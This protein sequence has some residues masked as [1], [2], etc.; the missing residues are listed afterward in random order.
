[1]SA[2]YDSYLHDHKENVRLAMEWMLDN[3][4]LTDDP[5]VR[6]DLVEMAEHHDDSKLLPDEYEAYDQYFYDDTPADPSIVND[7]NKA[8]MLHIHR[9]PHHWQYWLLFHD[10]DAVIEP[11]EMPFTYMVEM[12]ADWWSFS[13]KKGNLFEIFDWYEGRR[14]DQI[15]LHSKTRERVESLLTMMRTALAVKLYVSDTDGDDVCLS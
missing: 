3:L 5:F 6:R 2:R 1:M 13:W 10:D 11:I 4:N 14:E 15:I 12:V 7:F 8:F 9:N